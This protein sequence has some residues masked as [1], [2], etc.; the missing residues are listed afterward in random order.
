M[1]GRLRDAI[2]GCMHRF[3]WPTLGLLLLAVTVTG[4]E[5]KQNLTLAVDSD[6][7]ARQLVFHWQEGGRSGLAVIATDGSGFRWLPGGEKG[8]WASW[9]P[10]GKSTLFAAGAVGDSPDETDLYPLRHRDTDIAI[11]RTGRTTVRLA[12]R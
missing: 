3:C 1:P 11:P 9:S 12:G 10:D 5:I 7:S 6:Q 8:L 2:L 4:C